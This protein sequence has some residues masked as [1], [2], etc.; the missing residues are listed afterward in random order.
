M[1]FELG[2]VGR[3]FCIVTVVIC[4]KVREHNREDFSIDA[5]NDTLDPAF[6]LL[7]L[8]ADDAHIHFVALLETIAP[9]LFGSG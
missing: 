5:L 1:S 2:D 6:G 9:L 4:R 8:V 7:L 3:P